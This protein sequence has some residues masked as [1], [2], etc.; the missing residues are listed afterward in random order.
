MQL[1]RV[2]ITCLGSLALI[3]SASAQS[4]PVATACKTDIARYCA[5]KGHGNRQTRTCLE[6]NK[7]KVSDGCKT[8]LETTGGGK[9]R[10]RKN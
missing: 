3:S 1:K 10:N 6:T 8:A 4:G 5:G 2:L 9:G 7:A